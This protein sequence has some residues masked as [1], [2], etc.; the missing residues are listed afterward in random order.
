MSETNLQPAIHHSRGL[1]RAKV[2]IGLTWFM[3]CA[4]F[5]TLIN[6]YWVN[7]HEPLHGWLAA[8]IFVSAMA[9]I[10]IAGFQAYKK[11]LVGPALTQNRPTKSIY[12]TAIVSSIIW[13]VTILILSALVLDGGRV[14]HI[15]VVASTA[16]WPMTALITFRRPTSPTTIDLLAIRWGYPLM[17]L[18][19]GSI[20]PSI[21]ASLGRW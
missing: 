9:A 18:V 21:W 17:V 16:F 12:R 20:G 3:L 10:S 13:Q 2:A 6:V 11:Q 14:F 4:I 8:M 1:L 15:C 19:V 5:G 7:Q